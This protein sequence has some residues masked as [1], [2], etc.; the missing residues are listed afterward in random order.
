MRAQMGK[1]PDLKK[2]REVHNQN[3]AAQAKF[4][5]RQAKAEEARKRGASREEIR[6]IMEV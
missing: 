5:D 6:R 1:R 4:A 2:R 3:K